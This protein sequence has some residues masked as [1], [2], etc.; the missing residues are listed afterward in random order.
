MK[1]I[2]FD[3]LDKA[4]SNLMEKAGETPPGEQSEGAVGTAA[5]STSTP[6]SSSSTPVAI[7]TPTPAAPSISTHRSGRFMDVVHPSSD[8]STTRPA[9]DTPPRRPRLTIIPTTHAAPEPTTPDTTTLQPD[10]N[11]SAPAFDPMSSSAYDS[12]M[13]SEHEDTADLTA[14]S[15]VDEPSAPEAV[16]ESSKEIAWPD[17]LDMLQPA[18][19]DPV[20]S[21][22]STESK[23]LEADLVPTPESTSEPSQDSDISSFNISSDEKSVPAPA[24]A[25]TPPVDTAETTTAAETTEPNS[26]TLLEAGLAES[27][28]DTQPE[29]YSPFL[30]D[31]K[32]EKR[33]LGSDAPTEPI[34]LIQD[35]QQSVPEPTLPQELQ[36]DIVELESSESLDTADTA[37]PETVPEP[38]VDTL[39]TPPEQTPA[40]QSATEP[41]AAAATIP[42]ARRVPQ[43][44][45]EPEPAPS[46]GPGS[47][48]PQYREEAKAADEPQ[49]TPIYDTSSYHKPL[50]HPAKK[51]SGWLVVLI[52]FLLLVAGA[53]GAAALFY[54]GII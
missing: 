40:D 28:T 36:H 33:P 37:E 31:A 4:V 8:M 48:A 18:A 32:I 21:A 23:A 42:A 6:S 14:A 25:F 1:D 51:K 49:H 34:A 5:V 52:V 43:H 22:N 44:T 20:E 53:G 39:T 30:T 11:D 46:N 26:G 47:I 17:P 19:N 29:A 13:P 16:D 10:V 38:Q 3:E 35:D 54:A 2:D 27:H 12:S 41:L 15:A 45:V 9:I 7:D 24:P 50:E